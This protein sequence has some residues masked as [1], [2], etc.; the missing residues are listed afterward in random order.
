MASSIGTSK[1]FS[2]Q[3]IQMFDHDPGSSSA[4]VVTPDGGTTERWFDLRDFGGFAVIAMSSTLTGNGISKLE[5]V[6]NTASDGSGTTV[7]IKD[8]GAVLADAVGDYVVEE[9]TAIEVEDVGN[10]ESTP[11][12]L[13]YVAGRLT[14]ANSAD[15]AVVTYVGFDPRFARLDLTAD[16]IA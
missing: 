9:C 11:V 3:L 8:S 2:K 4:K 12:S 5:I 16:T 1:L 7:V 13:R 6:A 15:E 14:V 10:S